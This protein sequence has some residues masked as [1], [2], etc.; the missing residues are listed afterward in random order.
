MT[1]RD[2]AGE[3]MA[4]AI[5]AKSQCGCTLPDGEAVF[6]DDKRLAEYVRPRSCACK[7]EGS[8]SLTALLSLHPSLASVLD[9]TGVVVPV[10]SLRWW[11]ELVD[12]NP[13][14]LAPRVDA[15]LAAR[16]VDTPPT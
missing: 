5:R 10:S 14:D 8:V 13:A 16:L 7:S 2:K 9:G 15:M 11:R 3:A 4:R 6:C 1:E 12:L